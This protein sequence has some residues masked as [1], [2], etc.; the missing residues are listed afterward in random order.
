MGDKGLSKNIFITP[1]GKNC[2]LG[3][4]PILTGVLSFVAPFVKN[5]AIRAVFI[6][7]IVILVI[8]NI[9]A[10]Y[11]YSKYEN[12]LDAKVEE[13]TSKLSVKEKELKEKEEEHKRLE[14]KQKVLSHIIATYDELLNKYSLKITEITNDISEI[15][16]AEKKDWN[17]STL[18]EEI[19]RSC[20]IALK[21]ENGVENN[22]HVS[23]IRAYKD[24]SNRECI[25]MIA[26]SSTSKPNVYMKEEVL[27]ECTYYY[28]SL[29]REKNPDIVAVADHNTLYHLFRKKNDRTDLRKYSQYI[30]LPILCNHNQIIGILQIVMKNNVKLRETDL[31]LQ[32]LAE[33]YVEPFAQLIL[34]VLKLDE[35]LFAIPKV[36][37]EQ[38]EAS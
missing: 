20:C 32:Q 27:S 29:I 30:A 6:F 22:I 13:V 18:C 14:N 5:E 28:A 11:Y 8:G 19:C 26:H 12:S 34:L 2:I 4:L 24:A 23:F 1:I 37:V 17:I 35:G 38:K 16:K 31:D 10:I 15:G 21:K 7:A 36:V 33:V 25:K 9:I 3:G